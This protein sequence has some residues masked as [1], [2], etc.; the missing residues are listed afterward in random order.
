MLQYTSG[1]FF[2]KYLFLPDYILIHSLCHIKEKHFSHV[3]LDLFF[4]KLKQLL[5]C[6]FS[7]LVG[8]KVNINV[9]SESLE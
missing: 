7:Q 4:D 2:M 9:K 3:Y 8:S 1:Q 5:P 6:F